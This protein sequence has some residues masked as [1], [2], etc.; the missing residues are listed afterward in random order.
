MQRSKVGKSCGKFRGQGRQPEQEQA[1]CVPGPALLCNTV[2]CAV[3]VW[4]KERGSEGAGTVGV[5]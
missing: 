1:A 4:E 3:G 2:H 5:V